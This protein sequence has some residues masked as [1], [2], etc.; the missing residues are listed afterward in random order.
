[1]DSERI[2]P[3]G[4]LAS[5]CSIWSTNRYNM[6]WINF[7]YL[8]S[9]TN[10]KV[11]YGKFFHVSENSGLSNTRRFCF[12]DIFY[13]SILKYKKYW[14]VQFEKSKN[15]ERECVC[16]QKWKLEMLVRIR[17]SECEQETYNK[18]GPMLLNLKLN[19]SEKLSNETT[20]SFVLSFPICCL[21][22]QS[23]RITNT[24]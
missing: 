15:I 7:S 24:E 6:K 14:F 19:I 18:L 9:A 23:Q 4:V 16:E 17:S 21:N 3:S 22:P 13:L 12:F 10:W 8:L 11:T 2:R 1:V 20:S 5:C